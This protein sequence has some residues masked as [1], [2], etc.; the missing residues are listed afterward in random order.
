VKYYVWSI[1]FFGAEILTLCKVNQEYQESF[2][3]WC[4]RRTEKNSRSDCVRCE[5]V[6]QI[7]KEERNILQTIKRMKAN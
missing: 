7:V 5:E 4:W 1:A 3:M 2:E 6:L